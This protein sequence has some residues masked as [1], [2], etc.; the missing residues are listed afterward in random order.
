MA[1]GQG[2]ERESAPQPVLVKP[3]GQAP[4]HKLRD[5]SVWQ[6]HTAAARGGRWT[7]SSSRARAAGRQQGPKERVGLP[8]ALRGTQQQSPAAM[9]GA[10][11]SLIWLRFRYRTAVPVWYR[12]KAVKISRATTFADFRSDSCGQKSSSKSFQITLRSETEIPEGQSTTHARVRSLGP[13]P[14]SRP[15]RSLGP[16]SSSPAAGRQADRHRHSSPR[17]ASYRTGG[18]GVGAGT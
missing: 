13:N 8:Y 4:L 16:G 11:K 7:P 15:I 1:R 14:L 10:Q 2:G 6:P 5:S 9:S 17:V 3:W 18:E 12:W